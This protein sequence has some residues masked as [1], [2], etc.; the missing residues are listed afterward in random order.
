MSPPTI[1]TW[2]AKRRWRAS[3]REY[4]GGVLL[5]S[6]DRQLIAKLQPLLAD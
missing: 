6:H 3:L 1:W 5:V 2:K 4:S